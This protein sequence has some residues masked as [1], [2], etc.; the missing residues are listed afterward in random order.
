MLGYLD[1]AFTEAGWGA[2]PREAVTGEVRAYI[3]DWAPT[4]EC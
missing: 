1:K 4:P 3:P 2:V